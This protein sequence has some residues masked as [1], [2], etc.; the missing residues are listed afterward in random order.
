[1]KNKGFNEFKNK[2]GDKENTDN[3]R[4]KAALSKAI[5]RNNASDTS[6]NNNSATSQDQTTTSDEAFQNS[7]I[8]NTELSFDGLMKNIP[9]TPEKIDTS[10]RIISVNLFVLG[11]LYQNELEDYERAIDAYEEHLQRYPSV[12]FGGELYLNLFYCYSKLGNISK[13]NYY[14]SLLNGKYAGSKFAS[15]A[16]NPSSLHPNRQD[17]VVTKLYEGIYTLFIEG[18][19]TE[20]LSQ[21]QKADNVHGTNYWTPQLL[22]IESVYYI[23]QRSDSIAIATLE[24]SLNLFPRSIMVPKTQNLIDVLKRRGEIEDYLTKLN[25]TRAVEEQLVVTDDGAIIKVKP[26]IKEPVVRP[27]VNISKP[28]TDSVKRVPIRVDTV[29]AIPPADTVKV[30]PPVDTIKIIP[31]DTVKVT[32]PPVDTVKIIP[33]DT[34]KVAPPPADTVKTIP[35]DTVKVTPPPVDTVKIIPIDTVK[36]APP[37]ADT[38]KNNSQIL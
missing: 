35:V 19:F 26:E 22:Y 32:P 12:L 6:G 7:T 29:K 13:A 2:W 24:K 18:S 21:K 34:V 5:V 28:P 25:I 1:M 37:P 27:N 17:P 10:N 16:N 30:T 23:R 15:M 8:T 14:K 38:V 3:W 11:K 4:R 33:I 9:L 20:A 31:A 36:V